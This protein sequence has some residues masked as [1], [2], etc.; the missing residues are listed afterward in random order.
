MPS[1]V[2]SRWLPILRDHLGTRRDALD[3]AMGTGRHARAAAGH[4]FRVFGVDRNLDRV[5]RARPGSLEHAWLWVADLET[6][7]LPRD[8]FDLIICTNYLQRSIWPALRDAVRAGGFVIYETFTVAQL[9]HGTGPRSPDHLL[10][11]GELRA[12]FDGWELC[13]DEE[14]TAPAG[15]ARLVARKRATQTSSRVTRVFLTRGD[16]ESPRSGAL[17][18]SSTSEACGWWFRDGACADAR[19]AP[20]IR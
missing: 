5:Q 1:P 8:R 14:C 2:V 17:R 16:V 10:R 11:L 9:A 15:V 19:Q 3:L 4:G 20:D 13:H 7:T 6:V 18:K 12:A